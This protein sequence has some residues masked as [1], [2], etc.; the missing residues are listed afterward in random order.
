M[1][2]PRAA[3]TMALGVRGAAATIKTSSAGYI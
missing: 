1:P 2:P 3:S